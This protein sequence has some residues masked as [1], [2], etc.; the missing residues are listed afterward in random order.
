MEKKHTPVP[1]NQNLSKYYKQ[2][3]LVDHKKPKLV[4]PSETRLVQTL[5][6]NNKTKE[7]QK[8]QTMGAGAS[9]PAPADDNKSSD[10]LVL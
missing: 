7:T 8:R 9:V 3:Q 6:A 1:R 4:K 10:T 2:V 5:A